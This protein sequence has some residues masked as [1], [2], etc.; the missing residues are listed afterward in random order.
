MITNLPI[1]LSFPVYNKR[2]LCVGKIMKLQFSS[3]YIHIYSLM[4][5][6][7]NNLNSNLSILVPDAKKGNE[8]DKPKM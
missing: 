4:L 8:N 6:I 2:M 7:F 3:C 1:T 5:F